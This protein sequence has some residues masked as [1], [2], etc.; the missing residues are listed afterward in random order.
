MEAI[1]NLL[2][3]IMSEKFIHV[4]CE[5]IFSLNSHLLY[6]YAI[7]CEPFLL[8]TDIYVR[9]MPMSGISGS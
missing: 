9:H 1:F 3:N 7:M 6:I 2:F 4:A 8:S 5:F